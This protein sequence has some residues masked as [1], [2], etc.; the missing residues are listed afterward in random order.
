MRYHQKTGIEAKKNLQTV[1][2]LFGGSNFENYFE[3]A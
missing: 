3:I 2:R 1:K